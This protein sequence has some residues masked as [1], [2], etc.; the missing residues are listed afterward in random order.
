MKYT[1]LDERDISLAR[2]HLFEVR[3]R[4]LVTQRSIIKHDETIFKE[5]QLTSICDELNVK[6]DRIKRSRMCGNKKVIGNRKF[7]SERTMSVYDLIALL[8]I[9]PMLKSMLMYTSVEWYSS[10]SI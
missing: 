7:L 6:V 9:K 3:K 10:H 2:E 1:L 8:H 5:K 4:I